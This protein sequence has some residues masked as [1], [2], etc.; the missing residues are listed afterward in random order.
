M[1]PGWDSSLFFGQSE[2]TGEPG[3]ITHADT[4]ITYETVPPKNNVY[5]QNY[6]INTQN[7]TYDTGFQVCDM[8]AFLLQ[9]F[10]HDF[11]HNT[12]NI[13]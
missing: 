10:I 2:E 13:Y 11:Q 5:V 12:H 9:L 4:V 8:T 7:I 6:H 3:G 1:H